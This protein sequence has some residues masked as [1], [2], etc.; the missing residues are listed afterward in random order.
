MILIVLS[1]LMMSDHSQRLERHAGSLAVVLFFDIP[2]DDP[3]VTAAAPAATA[4]EDLF[5]PRCKSGT[6]CFF[7]F[8]RHCCVH[9][10]VDFN[11]V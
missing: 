2:G 11:N 10:L 6:F 7:F 8:F 1:S 3:G 4:A 9:L 5:H